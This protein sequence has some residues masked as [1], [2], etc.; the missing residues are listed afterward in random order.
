[1]AY[2][3]NTLI[4]HTPAPGSRQW[5]LLRDH[6]LAVAEMAR[7]FAE[8]FG[9]DTLAYRVGLLHDTGKSNPDF[10][11]YLRRCDADPTFKGRGPDHKAAGATLAQRQLAPLALLVQGHHG[12]LKSKEEFAAWLAERQKDRVD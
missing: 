6:T 10:Q 11:A 5:H 1:M 9:A 7:R 8:P 3:D 12:G 4:A 2:L